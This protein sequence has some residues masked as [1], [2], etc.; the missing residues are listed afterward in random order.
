MVWPF[1]DSLRKV[2]DLEPQVR[3]SDHA[4]PAG[5]LG[6]DAVKEVAKLQTISSDEGGRSRRN[7]LAYGEAFSFGAFPGRLSF[8]L[9][10]HRRK[11]FL[12]AGFA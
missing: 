10:G 5:G 7:Q 12:R 8:F 11:R 2:G 4:A 6:R 1:R 9:L 3:S